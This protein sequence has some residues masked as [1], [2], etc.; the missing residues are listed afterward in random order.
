MYSSVL[1]LLLVPAIFPSLFSIASNQISKILH[2]LESYRYLLFPGT[3]LS[4]RL[5]IHSTRLCHS[6]LRERGRYKGGVYSSGC[7]P[8]G[9]DQKVGG[10][11][12]SLGV[13]SRQQNEPQNLLYIIETWKSVDSGYG[14]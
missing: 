10:E 6:R 8:W 2:H 12:H 11:V 5:Y 4:I 13:A 7:Q 1:L 3:T 9:R 14:D